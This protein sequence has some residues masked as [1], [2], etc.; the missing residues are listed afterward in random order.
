M[1][2]LE[3][4]T[5]PNGSLT[6][7]FATLLWAAALLSACEKPSM[8]NGSIAMTKD[9]LEEAYRTHDA[10]LA[11]HQSAERVLVGPSGIT[12]LATANPTGDAEHTWVLRLNLQGEVAW[13]H[14]YEPKYGAARAIAQLP[15]GGL[16]LA[17]EVA[18]SATA[19]QGMLLTTNDHG[20]VTAAKALGPRGLTG[21]TSLTVRPDGTI[22][23]GGSASR[24]WLVSSDATL[25][26]PTEQTLSALD[27]KA[28]SA[29]AGGVTA[30]LAVAE[31]STTGFGRATLF[32]LSAGYAPA[33][34]R[35]LPTGE[36]GDPAA[37]VMGA[38]GVLAMGSG[39]KTEHDLAHVWLAYVDLAGKVRWERTLTAGEENARGWAAV[40]LADGYAVVGETASMDGV[41]SPHVWRLGPDGATLW[42][43]SYPTPPGSAAFEIV[44]SI[45]SAP[46][47]GFVL[48]GS[49]SRGEGKTNVW[50]LRLDAQGQVIWQR[51]FGRAASGP[52]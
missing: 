20:N 17:G 23:A 4:K 22:L 10:S 42:D 30:V 48:A 5:A 12:V 27:V 16:A 34:E 45:A 9:D 19:Y 11:G 6:F 32:A 52:A 38:D 37:L 51:V 7:G 18:R 36:H 46:D 1:N 31:R 21:F 24:G 47:G 33:W 29:G 15:G 40:G 14:H 2:H 28:L 39:A 26:S 3:L 43:R 50:V 41:R 13:Q 49:T 44:N 25:R 35:A 8:N